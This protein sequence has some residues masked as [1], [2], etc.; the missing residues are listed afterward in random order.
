MTSASYLPP[1]GTTFGASIDWING[2]LLGSLAISL[3]VIAVALVGLMMVGGRLPV[4]KGLRVILGCFILL[5]APVIAA[6]FMG[7]WRGGDMPAHESPS[8]VEF[9]GPRE[10][11]PPANYDPY[12]GASLRRD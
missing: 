7:I 9:A 4:R 1:S 3:C 6:G 12:A 11:P 2:L 8:L 10:E 5:G